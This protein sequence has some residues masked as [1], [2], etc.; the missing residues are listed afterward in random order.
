MG[1]AF[2]ALR[3]KSRTEFDWCIEHLT[4]ETFRARD[5]WDT[6]KALDKSFKQYAVELNLTPHFWNLTRRAHQ[7]MVILRLGRLYDPHPT[8]I[9]LGTLLATMK[10]HAGTTA[11]QFPLGV[12]KLDRAKFDPEMMSVS[13]SDPAVKNLLALRNE[14][15]AHRGFQHVAKGTFKQL[16]TL[17]RRDIAKLINRAIGI[18]GK[19]R[20]RLGYPPLGWGNYEGR[21][22]NTLLV[23][24]RTGR[25]A[26]A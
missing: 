15:L 4:H 18:V 14:Y 12:T 8:A 26:P 20:H 9:S 3:V 2:R 10:Q 24:L 13:D 5:H 7:D 11:P 6:W 19:Y 22:V 17:G 25:R 1:A 16:P 23:L 21:D